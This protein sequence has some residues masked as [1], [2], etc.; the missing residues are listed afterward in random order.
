M[1]VNEC[2]PE[3]EKIVQEGK[4]K[5]IGITSYNLAVL[6]ECVKRAPCVD[7]IIFAILL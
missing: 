6:K 3:L 4:A 7:V 5:F 1:I 2:L